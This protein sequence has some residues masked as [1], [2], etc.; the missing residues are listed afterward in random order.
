[1]KKLLPL[2]FISVGVI[3]LSSCGQTGDLYLPKDKNPYKASSETTK[4]DNDPT[5][6]AKNFNPSSSQLIDSGDN[7]TFDKDIQDSSEA[8]GTPT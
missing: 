5:P 3:G 7:F 6:P 4:V 8:G 2:V 1:M